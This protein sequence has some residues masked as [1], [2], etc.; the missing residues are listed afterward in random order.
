MSVDQKKS[1][2]KYRRSARQLF[3]AILGLPR[4]GEKFVQGFLFKIEDFQL[5]NQVDNK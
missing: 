5:D 4:D 3:F 1:I 2:K